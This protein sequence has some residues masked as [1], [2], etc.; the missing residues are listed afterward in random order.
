MFTASWKSSPTF[1]DFGTT[2]VKDIPRFG[3]PKDSFRECW[4]VRVTVFKTWKKTCASARLQLN[5]MLDFLRCGAPFLTICFYN[6]F[7]GSTSRLVIEAPLSPSL[8]K[9]YCVIGFRA[10]QCS[11]RR[12]RRSP[13]SAW[14]A[15]R[16]SQRSARERHHPEREGLGRIS[17]VCHFNNGWRLVCSPQT[18]MILST[19]ELIEPEGNMVALFGRCCVTRT[20]TWSST[21]GHAAS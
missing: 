8:L 14:T 15:M 10:L 17:C 6:N 20:S 2:E 13:P 21:T 3:S 12:R 18:G 9:E 16:R 19:V 7:V 11:R 1:F 4:T 5:V